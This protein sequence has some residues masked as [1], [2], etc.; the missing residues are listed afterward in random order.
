MTKIE[1]GIALNEQHIYNIENKI[2]EKISFVDQIKEIGFTDLEDFFNQKREY[3]MQQVLNGKVYSV[4]PKDAMPTL[5]LLLSTG[6]FGIVSVYT[7]E[8]CVHHGQDESKSLNTEYCETH[9]IPIYTYDSFGGSIVATED[10]YSMALLLPP[11]ID[12]STDFILKKF[13]RILLKYFNNVTIDNN[14]I[15]INGVKVAGTTSFGTD[16]FFFLIAHFSM[17]EKTDLIYSICGEPT[18]NKTPGYIDTSIL[19]TE[20]LMEELLSWLQG[21]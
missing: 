15:L 20:K 5:R 12:I 16:T 2:E 14:D 21:L 9:N 8:T 11:D 6:Q 4:A 17:N 18:S 19:S 13:Q 7:N 1:Q 3:D 10:D